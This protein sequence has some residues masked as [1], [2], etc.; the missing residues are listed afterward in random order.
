MLPLFD[1]EQLCGGVRFNFTKYDNTRSAKHKLFFRDWQERCKEAPSGPKRMGRTTQQAERK[2]S[3]LLKEK[4]R[5]LFASLSQSN[6]T[7]DTFET[8]FQLGCFINGADNEALVRFPTSC[9]L[10]KILGE[11]LQKEGFKKKW[12]VTCWI[13]F[14]C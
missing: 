6:I 7:L 8:G 5:N 10:N 13:M 1:S 9:F 3:R 4:E 14:S 11:K 12:Y 2:H